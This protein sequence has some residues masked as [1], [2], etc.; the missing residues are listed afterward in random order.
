MILTCAFNLFLLI[1]KFTTPF[2]YLQVAHADR[3]LHQ[4]VFGGKEVIV[5]A[6]NVSIIDKGEY[7]FKK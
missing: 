2:Y 5:L 6:Y 7:L 4:G 1:C 3:Q